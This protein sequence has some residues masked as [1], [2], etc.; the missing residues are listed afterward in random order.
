MKGGKQVKFFLSLFFFFV[1]VSYSWAVGRDRIGE[2]IKNFSTAELSDLDNETGKAWD[3]TKEV[4]F[5]GTLNGKKTYV[6]LGINPT[7]SFAHESGTETYKEYSEMIVELP[8]NLKDVFWDN[9][10]DMFT[11]IGDSSHEN[12]SSAWRVFDRHMSDAGKTLKLYNVR[13][14]PLAAGQAFVATLGGAYYLV[15]ELPIDTAWYLGAGIVT[16]TVTLLENPVKGT[17][18]LVVGSVVTTYGVGSSIIGAVVPASVTVVVAVAEG[19]KFLL[20]TGPK[21]IFSRIF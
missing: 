15:I 13:G 8:E 14:V 20:W 4:F 7:L 11:K 2:P 10:K 5:E 9:P 18:A 16:S 6:I 17:L 19:L 21:K 1:V 12:L 3:Y